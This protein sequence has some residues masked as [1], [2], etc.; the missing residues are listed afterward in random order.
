MR[1]GA[2]DGVGLPVAE[3]VGE[4]LGVHDIVGV[5]LGVVLAGT[6]ATIR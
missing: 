6:P 5:T 1:A 2:G 3:G 4:T